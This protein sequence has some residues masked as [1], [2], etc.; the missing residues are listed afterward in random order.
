MSERERETIAGCGVVDE[1]RIRETGVEIIVTGDRSLSVSIMFRARP[2]ESDLCRDPWWILQELSP[3]DP[4]LFDAYRPVGVESS[5]WTGNRIGRPI[6]SA[7]SK[8]AA[9][10]ALRAADVVDA[11]EDQF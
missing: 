6:G 3:G 4:V 10:R 2:A 8:A 11:D 9:A 7:S 1:M 5:T